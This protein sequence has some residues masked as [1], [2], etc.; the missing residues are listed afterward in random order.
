MKKKKTGYD[1]V[2]D[3]AIYKGIPSSSSHNSSSNSATAFLSSENENVFVDGEM[4]FV[5]SSGGSNAGNR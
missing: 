1:Q 5:A 4:C 3:L 2:Q